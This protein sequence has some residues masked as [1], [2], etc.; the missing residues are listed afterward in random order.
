MRGL[1][2]ILVADRKRLGQTA[3]TGRS[4]IST[5]ARVSSYK[6]TLERYGVTDVPAIQRVAGAVQA[7]SYKMKGSTYDSAGGLATDRV[8]P[9][10]IA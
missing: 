1:P 4:I 9:R 7:N 5:V 6:P 8:L 10:K 2:A 3:V